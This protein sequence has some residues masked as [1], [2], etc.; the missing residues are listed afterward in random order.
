MSSRSFNLLLIVHGA[1]S[2]CYKTVHEKPTSNTRMRKVF[3]N[4]SMFYNL[5]HTTKAIRHVITKQCQCN[6]VFCG[7]SEEN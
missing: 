7:I 4:E 3:T 1:R 2:E 5:R 6:E